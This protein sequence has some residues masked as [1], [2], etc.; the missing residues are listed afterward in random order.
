[1]TTAGE[2]E[3]NSVLFSFELSSFWISSV[4]GYTE[5]RRC[6]SR[7]LATDPMS[8]CAE[9]VCYDKTFHFKG[10]A[11]LPGLLQRRWPPIGDEPPNAPP[12]PLGN[13]SPAWSQFSESFIGTLVEMFLQL[14]R[15]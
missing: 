10:F 1:M 12:L 4:F 2:F 14:S 8:A 11:N 7:L 15:R 3:M 5:I 6:N 13:N 9:T